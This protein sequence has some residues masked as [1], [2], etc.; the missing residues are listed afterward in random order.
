MDSN[1]QRCQH[2][3]NAT[4]TAFNSIEWIRVCTGWAGVPRVLLDFQFH[5]MDSGVPRGPGSS[6]A[7]PFNSIEWIPSNSVTRP[8]LRHTGLSIPLNGF[9][10]DLLASIGAKFFQFHWMDSMH[11]EHV[12]VPHLATFNSIEWIP[13]VQDS[14]VHPTPTA[15]LSIPLN[16]FLQSSGWRSYNQ[17]AVFQFHWMDSWRSWISL[18]AMC[19]RV[20]SIPLNGFT[21]VGSLGKLNGELGFQFHWMDS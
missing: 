21:I 6:V 19:L 11:L 10:V 2:H 13:E 4:N 5:W 7:W 9:T 20:L 12:K 1:V 3:N 18:L 14:Q 15:I 17:I 8:E 16:G